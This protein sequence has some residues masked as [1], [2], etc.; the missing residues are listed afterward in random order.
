MA[1]Y[2][3]TTVPHVE[4]DVDDLLRKIALSLSNSGGGGGGGGGGTP[5]PVIPHFHYMDQSESFTIPS[6]SKGWTS[7]ILTGT[8]SIGGVTVS[9]G[10]SDSDAG[11]TAADITIQTFEGSTAYVRYNS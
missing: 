9:A 10:F 2:N 11:T 8:G 6:G 3:A 1:E 4:D 7:T 5:A